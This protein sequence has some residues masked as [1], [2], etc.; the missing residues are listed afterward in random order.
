MSIHHIT[1]L[2]FCLKNTYF[3]IQGRYFEQVHGAVMGALISSFVAYPSMEECETKAINTATNLSIVLG[4]SGPTHNYCIRKRNTYRRANKGASI[5]TGHL[6]DSKIK[7]NHKYNTEAHH[8]ISNNNQSNM[9][10]VVPYRE[11]KLK[12]KNLLWL[13]ENPSPLQGM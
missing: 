10:M 12:I 9:H 11:I 6:L 13:N 4:L 3:C 5:L 7:S 8:N 2:E 1:T